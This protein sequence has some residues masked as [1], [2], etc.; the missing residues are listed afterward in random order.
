MDT[1]RS[2]RGA[3]YMGIF[4]HCVL[5]FPRLCFLFPFDLV[6]FVSAMAGTNLQCVGQGIY[7]KQ[8]CDRPTQCTYSSVFHPA[9]LHSSYEPVGR[10]SRDVCATGLPCSGCIEFSPWTQTLHRC[11]LQLLRI[12]AFILRSFF[13]PLNSNIFHFFG[14]CA[15]RCYG[16]VCI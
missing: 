16:L 9:Q 13:I 7:D 6:L 15:K 11:T 2:Y 8:D 4:L 10:A 12:R 14:F 5:H 3:A 1:S